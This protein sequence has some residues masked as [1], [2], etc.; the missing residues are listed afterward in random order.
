MSGCKNDPEKLSAT[1]LGEHVSSDFTMS[2]VPSFKDI[3]N[4]RCILW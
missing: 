2:T 3:K 4:T 1:K